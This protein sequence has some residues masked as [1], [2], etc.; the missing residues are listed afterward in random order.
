[1]FRNSARRLA[2]PELPEELFV[3][4]LRALVEVDNRWV[5]TT[6]GESLYL[7]PFMI[8]TSVGLG[9][10]SPASEYLYTLIGSPAASYF[11]GG[12]KPVSVWLTTEFVRAAPG[13]TGF[14]KCAGNY[15]ASFV[16]QAQA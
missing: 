13:G 8:S 3:E 10:N 9:V 5:P 7:R 4:S 15:A 12:V 1:R 16:A 11:A 14:A 2:M 6:P